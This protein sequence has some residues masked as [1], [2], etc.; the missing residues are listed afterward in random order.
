M[1]GDLEASVEDAAPGA[2]ADPALSLT[3]IQA[4]AWES[5]WD[6]AEPQAKVS[7]ISSRRLALI[8]TAGVLDALT[9]VRGSSSSIRFLRPS[10]PRDCS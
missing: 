5:V 2:N 3:R 9:A 8:P 7:E 6:L 10:K 1:L 4:L